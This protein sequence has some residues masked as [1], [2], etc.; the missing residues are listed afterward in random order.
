AQLRGDNAE[1]V[2]RWQVLLTQEIP[3]EFRRVLES[4]I[5]GID[6]GAL[7][8]IV[9]VE[10]SVA[11]ELVDELPARSVL[12]VA[13]RPAGDAAQ[14]PPVAARRLEFFNLPEMVPLMQGD[15][16]QALPEGRMQVIARL[17]ASG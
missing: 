7:D 2:R 12:F 10:V 8:A 1:A 13:L 5:A 6:P 16:L 14:G 9:L 15:L 17:S 4:R 11:P 3:V